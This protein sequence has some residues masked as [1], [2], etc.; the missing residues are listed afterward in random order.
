MI[1]RRYAAILLLL[2][3]LSVAGD[4]GSRKPSTAARRPTQTI[5]SN[6]SRMRA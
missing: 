2:I 3:F 1:L 6:A 5:R 4:S